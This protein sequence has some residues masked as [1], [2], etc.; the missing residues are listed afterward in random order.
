MFEKHS[1]AKSSHGSD[2]S[3]LVRTVEVWDPHNS[4][5]GKWEKGFQAAS[6]PKETLILDIKPQKLLTFSLPTLPSRQHAHS[7]SC[8]PWR[9]TAEESCNTCLWQIISLLRKIEKA[10]LALPQIST[11]WQLCV[12]HGALFWRYSSEQTRQAP[13][14]AHLLVATTWEINTHAKNNYNL[15]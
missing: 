3:F 8:K 9:V 7:D 1:P 4:S 11:R 13:Y 14:R 6:N 2:S 5:I 12:K 10:H 15:W